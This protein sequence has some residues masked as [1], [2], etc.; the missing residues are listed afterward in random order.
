MVLNTRLTTAYASPARSNAEH[1]NF[2]SMRESKSL[3]LEGQAAWQPWPEAEDGIH[4]AIPTPVGT[5]GLGGGPTLLDGAGGGAGTAQEHHQ[6][7]ERDSKRH[8]QQQHKRSDKMIVAIPNPE[9]ETETL[10]TPV[11]ASPSAPPTA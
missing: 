2:R 4:S 6:R 8:Q 3:D 9:V 7:G 5:P 1:T 10:K 11:C